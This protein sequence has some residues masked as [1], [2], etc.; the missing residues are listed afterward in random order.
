MA[1]AQLVGGGWLEIGKSPL[2]FETRPTLSPSLGQIK[3]F[4]GN[5]VLTVD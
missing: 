1:G 3:F 4:V 2:I 5:V